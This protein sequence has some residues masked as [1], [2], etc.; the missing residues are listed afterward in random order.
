MVRGYCNWTFG[1]KEGERIAIFNE[2]WRRL[3]AIHTEVAESLLAPLD[4]VRLAQ[5]DTETLLR[6]ATEMGTWCQAIGSNI[7]DANGN[8]LR[9]YATVIRNLVLKAA[10]LCREYGV[11]AVIPTDHGGVA[12]SKSEFAYDARRKMITA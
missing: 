9:S 11:I 1:W 5:R 2:R 8:H 6:L 10:R 4:N 7:D 12:A 3:V